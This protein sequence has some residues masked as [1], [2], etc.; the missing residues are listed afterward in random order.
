MR[1][2]IIG[3]AMVAALASFAFAMPAGAA[4]ESRRGGVDVTPAE[5]NVQA[6]KVREAFE[7]GDYPKVSESDRRIVEDYFTIISR[8]LTKR[9]SSL[10]M[11]GQEKVDVFNMQERI[12]GILAGG[13]DY[14]V[15]SVDN[16]TG[17]HF[18]KK[19]CVSAKQKEDMR[20]EEHD[21]LVRMYANHGLGGVKAK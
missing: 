17:S 14:H 11:S 10:A 8:I 19:E 6:D 3:M 5:F 12:N 13:A 2:R 16:M 21:A 20:R 18:K 15:C 7:N 1:K 4:G 9:G